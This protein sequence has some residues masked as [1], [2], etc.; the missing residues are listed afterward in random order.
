[1][2]SISLCKFKHLTDIRAIV[3]LKLMAG[4]LHFCLNIDWLDL[5]NFLYSKS[6]SEFLYVG[7]FALHVKLIM[8]RRSEWRVRY[9]SLI[10]RQGSRTPKCLL[11]V[12]DTLRW[13]N[14]RVQEW[15]SMHSLKN[16][17]LCSLANANV[18]TRWISSP[19]EL[20]QSV[21]HR[22]RFVLSNHHGPYY[23]HARLWELERF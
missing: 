8:T 10:D 9:L 19:R 2:H 1:M 23:C 15:S 13:S 18:K 21:D 20:N 5:Q 3:Y 12:L 6:S 11:V 16:L 7:H 22:G 14:L 4:Y 17:I